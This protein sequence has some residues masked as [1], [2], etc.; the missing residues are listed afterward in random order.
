[1]EYTV[2]TLCLVLHPTTMCKHSHNKITYN[3]KTLEDDNRYIGGLQYLNNKIH[4]SE[5]KRKK[6]N[7]FF[8]YQAIRGSDS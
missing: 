1:M 4:F 2:I 8:T 3:S 5:L 6:K 7:S